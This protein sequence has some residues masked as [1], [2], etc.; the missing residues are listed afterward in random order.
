MKILMRRGEGG[1]KKKE[2]KILRVLINYEAFIC[3]M[4]L[5]GGSDEI[6]WYVGAG[7][8]QWCLLEQACEKGGACTL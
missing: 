1:A 8:Y 6:I 3:T 2:E 5:T 7:G 4:S